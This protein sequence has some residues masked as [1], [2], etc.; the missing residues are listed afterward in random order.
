[1]LNLLMYAYIHVFVLMP[2]CYACVHTCVLCLWYLVMSAYIHL[3]VLLSSCCPHAHLCVLF[4]W[5][6]VIYVHIHVFVLIQL[7]MHV[8]AHVLWLLCCYV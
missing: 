5:D 6:L 2:S 7:V 3:F 4:L 1:M 8:Y